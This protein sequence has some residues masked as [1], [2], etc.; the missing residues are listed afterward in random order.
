MDGSTWLVHRVSVTRVQ[1]GGKLCIDAGGARRLCI[2]LL[3]P[4]VGAEEPGRVL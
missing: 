2:G 3:E 1:M 4:A